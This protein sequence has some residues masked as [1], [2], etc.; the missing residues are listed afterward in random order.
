MIHHWY[1]YTRKYSP[2]LIEHGAIVDQ[3]RAEG[4]TINE[5]TLS[6]T[7]PL[8]RKHINPFG[9][10]HFDVTRMRNVENTAEATSA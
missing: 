3:L 8:H 10:Y 7:T 4:H 6:Q 1:G 5:E 9:R 2:A